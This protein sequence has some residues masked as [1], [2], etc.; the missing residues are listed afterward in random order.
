MKE[1]LI[2][3]S[4]DREIAEI[5]QKEEIKMLEESQKTIERKKLNDK[6]N[7]EDDQNKQYFL[8]DYIF[9][10]GNMN[11]EK[12]TTNKKNNKKNKKGKKIILFSNS[13]NH[14]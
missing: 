2:I 6:S 8:S 5:L 12:N 4:Q 13:M 10:E 11:V 9:G 1:D 7:E 3:P 14:Y